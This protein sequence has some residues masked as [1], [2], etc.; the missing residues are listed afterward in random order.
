LVQDALEKLMAERTT[1]VIAHRLS[2]I[3]KVDRIH[4][5]QD[6]RIAETGSFNELAAREGGLFQHLL[7]LQFEDPEAWG[8]N[9][10]AVRTGGGA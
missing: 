5:L 7:Q 6:G 2:T 4:V 10:A 8:G 1:L 3:R 9:G